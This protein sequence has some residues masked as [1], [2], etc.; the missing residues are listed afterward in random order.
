[1]NLETS[2][3]RSDDAWPK[4]ITYRMNPAN[5]GCQTAAGIDVCVLA[6]NH[7]IDYGYAWLVET[8]DI[9]M[10]S[11]HWGS[12]WGYDVPHAHARNSSS[13]WAVGSSFPQGRM[14]SAYGHLAIAHFP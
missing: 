9:T 7:V 3:T 13:R 10:T 4:G 6:N 5:V 12:N 1:V 2:V 11:V 14:P 8:Q